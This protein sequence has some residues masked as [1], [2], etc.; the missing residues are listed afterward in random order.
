MFK[1]NIELYNKI[2]EY[3]YAY[4]LEDLKV[5]SK[6]YM[7]SIILPKFSNNKN[8]NSYSIISMDFNNLNTLN[9]KKGYDVGNFV[10]YTFLDLI[11]KHPNLPKNSKCIRIGG[12][13]FL[14]ILENC[15]LDIADSFVNDIHKIE[16]SNRDI[17]H[18]TSVS[19]SAIH[20]DNCDNIEEMLNLAEQNIGIQ[21]K[22]LDIDNLNI[23]YEQILEN[24]LS[25]IFSV[26]FK[27]LRLYNSILS[28]QD[29]KSIYSSFINALGTAL[30]TS[31][32]DKDLPECSTKR[33]FDIEPYIANQ[34]DILLNTNI[35]DSNLDEFDSD[36]YLKL[37][38]NLVVEPNTKHFSR[39]Y[40]TNFLLDENNKDLKVKY[41]SIAFIKL[42]NTLYSYESTNI[43]I[44]NVISNIY[45]HLNQMCNSYVFTDNPFSS[46]DKMHCIDLGGGDFLITCNPHININSFNLENCIRNF[47]N[48]NSDLLKLTCSDSSEIMNSS[49]YHQ[50]LEKLSEE[51]KINKN[52]FKEQLIHSDSFC[53]I[54]TV[55][56][57][58][59]VQYY[60]DNFP[61]PDSI[62]QKSNFI[63]IASNSILNSLFDFNLSQ[64]ENIKM[65]NKRKSL[66]CH[67]NSIDNIER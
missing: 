21:K 67:N 50:I 17:L 51:C 4:N 31:I 27:S 48:H 14:L 43:D 52:I 32:I 60:K 8:I 38:S 54:I 39:T 13:E 35:E 18:N 12:D 41:F 24:N 37:L 29:L 19:A 5:F 57:K 9:N 44:R 28:I 40:L 15:S 23:N 30:E 1:T 6:Q 11:L 42:H 10:I 64:L 53:D 45:S 16:H 25:K 22:S 55:L 58:D 33:T 46:N 66:K 47:N 63:N 36:V 3:M 20:S 61:N 7:H 65:H 49:N 56:L 34:L 62:S 59:V 2:K 26:L